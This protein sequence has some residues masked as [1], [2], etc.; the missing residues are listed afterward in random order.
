MSVSE[1]NNIMYIPLD[2]IMEGRS[3]NLRMPAAGEGMDVVPDVQGRD[4]PRART[5]TREGRMR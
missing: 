3:G 4:V 2:K 5:G 1:G